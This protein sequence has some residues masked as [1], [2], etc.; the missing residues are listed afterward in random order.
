MPGGEKRKANDS[1]STSAERGTNGQAL[2]V[3][4]AC[5]STSENI[6]ST[7]HCENAQPNNCSSSTSSHKSF[8]G[9]GEKPSSLRCGLGPCTSNWLQK[10]HTA[11]WLLAILCICAFNQS[12]VINA[13]FPVGLSTLEKR[14]HLNSTQTGIIS[15]W[16]DFAVLIAVFPVCCYGNYGHKGRWIAVG[17]LIMA[18]GSMVC[19]LS[20]FVSAPLEVDNTSLNSSDYGQCS[21]SRNDSRAKNLPSSFLDTSN[22]YFLM[23]LLGQTLHGFG[24]TPLFSLGTA[25][26]DENVSQKSSPVYLAIHS[27]LTSLGPIVGLFV[28]GKLLTIYDDFDRVDMDRLTMKDPKDPRWVGAWWI[29][30]SAC[31]IASLIIAFPIMVFYSS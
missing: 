7:S 20:H 18:L 1:P 15:S 17:S 26:L 24:A 6:P 31:S 21:F 29:G 19:A 11:R 13:I 3:E 27:F 14:F 8:S 30:F 16:Y 9:G 28:G 22:A 2:P 23:F 12:F 4:E 25:Y 10:L 5:S